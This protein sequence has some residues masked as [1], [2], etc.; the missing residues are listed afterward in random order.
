MKRLIAILFLIPLIGYSQTCIVA[1]KTKDKILV[2]ADSR[3]SLPKINRRTGET[4]ET[5]E[6]T[7]CK[8]VVGK[9]INFAI[10]GRSGSKLLSFASKLLNDT[11]SIAEFKYKYA[12]GAYSIVKK[13]FIEENT[14]KQIERTR[15]EVLT[16]MIIFGRENDSLK[17]IRISLLDSPDTRNNMDF[18]WIQEDIRDTIASGEVKEIEANNILFDKKT[19]QNGY[20][21]G[22]K[23]IINY[24]HEKHP[25]HV[26]GATNIVEVTK[27]KTKWIGKKPPCY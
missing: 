13:A 11:I 12:I 25:T 18:T 26:G 8:I 21:K 10:S 19:W 5:Y 15:N 9:N 1:V 6:D 7:I 2:G 20:I 27:R 14:V 24:A 16:D 3:V 4:T 17:L 23:Y 22:I